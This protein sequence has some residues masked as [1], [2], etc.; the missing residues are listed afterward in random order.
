MASGSPWTFGRT[1]Q[2]SKLRSKEQYSWRMADRL[3]KLAKSTAARRA[4][5]GDPDSPVGRH[6]LDIRTNRSRHG[7]SFT[8]ADHLDARVRPRDLATGSA[9]AGSG[10]AHTGRIPEG[11]GRRAS[12]VLGE[13]VISVMKM[14]A[15]A[16]GVLW[17]GAE[18]LVV[19][20]GLSWF[21]ICACTRGRRAWPRLPHGRQDRHVGG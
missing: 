4:A 3:E 10:L 14:R 20:L 13:G 21:L 8:P 19:T 17:R 15:R 6:L 9:N 1:A 16:N 18:W 7:R 11:N 2:E 5:L 12:S